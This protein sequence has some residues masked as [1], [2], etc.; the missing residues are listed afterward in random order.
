MA[1]QYI[2]NEEYERASQDAL[3]SK[4]P[5]E[6]VIVDDVSTEVNPEVVAFLNRQCTEEDAMWN[7]LE[8][9]SSADYFSLV[10]SRRI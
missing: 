4:R 3:W 8:N 7:D 2:T 6:P 10:P 5:G 1:V 9:T